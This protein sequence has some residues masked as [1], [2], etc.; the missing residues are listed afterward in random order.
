[1]AIAVR[2]TSISAKDTECKSISNQ[3]PI[4]VYTLNESRSGLARCDS[5]APR[6]ENCAHSPCMESMEHSGGP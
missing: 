2:S 1:M 3:K 5:F 4:N 6:F